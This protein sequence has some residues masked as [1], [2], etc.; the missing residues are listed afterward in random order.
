MALKDEHE[1]VTSGPYAAIRHPIY[2][3]LLLLIIGYV[4][5]NRTAFALIG[6]ALMMLSCWIKLRGEGRD[7]DRG[8]SRGLSGLYE[9]DQA[10]G[11]GADL[12]I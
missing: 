2:T 12:V 10:A 4:L 9:A 11:A 1:L 5:A 7:D 6:L 3:A 8:V